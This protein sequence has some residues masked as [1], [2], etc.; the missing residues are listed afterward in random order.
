MLKVSYI[1]AGVVALSAMGGV[2]LAEPSVSYGVTVTSNYVSGGVTQTD[3]GAA[4]Q[5][6]I[7]FDIGAGFYAGI[8][9]SNVDF[10]TADNFE[11]DLYVGYGGSFGSIEYDV[12]YLRYYYDDSGFD[13]EELILTFD[14]ALTDKIAASS[15]LSSDLMGAESFTQ[16]VSFEVADNYELSAEYA[17]DLSGDGEDWNLGVSR[18]LNDNVSIDLRYFEASGEDAEFALSISFDS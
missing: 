9:A 1:S 11:Y 3:G 15:S 6:Y 12:S 18:S 17:W 14:Y 16:G 2:A 10:G 7:E 13:S 8:W 5:P 4:I